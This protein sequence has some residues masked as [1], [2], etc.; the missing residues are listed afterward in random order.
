M[1][2]RSACVFSVEE[3][4]GKRVMGGDREENGQSGME[5]AK[6]GRLGN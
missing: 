1:G 5:D 2:M 6:L 4:V 3:E